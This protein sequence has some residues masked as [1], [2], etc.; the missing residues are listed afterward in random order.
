[1]RRQ[2]GAKEIS[3]SRREYFSCSRKVFVRMNETLGRFRVVDPRREDSRITPFELEKYNFDSTRG[4]LIKI[5]CYNSSGV[6]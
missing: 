6:F 3:S 4:I 5:V 2:N 1:M